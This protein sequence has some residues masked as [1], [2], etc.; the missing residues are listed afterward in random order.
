[1]EVTLVGANFSTR[2]SDNHV[3]LAGEPVVVRSATPSELRVLLP[4]DAETGTF[5]V[6]VDGA[7][8]AATSARFE[9]TVGL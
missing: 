2:L 4:S 1:S 5:E 7:A 8:A 9:V 6:R 3:T